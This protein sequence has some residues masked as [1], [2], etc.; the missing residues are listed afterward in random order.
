MPSTPSPSALTS[1]ISSNSTTQPSSPVFALS[2]QILHNL[3]HQHIWKSLQLHEPHSLSPQQHIPLISGYPPQTI[4]TH[5][6]EQ[7]YLL[8]HDIR[9]EAVPVEREWVIPCAQ[10]QSWSLRKFAGVF[11]SLPNRSDDIPEHKVNE[12]NPA[13]D[14]FSEFIRRKREEPWGGKRALLAMVNRGAGGDG[15]VVYYVMLEG[16][17]KPRQN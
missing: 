5:P 16:D 11:D 9:S 15:T 13:D 4:Y 17:V 6:D 2:L 7:A 12:G 3:E 10:G 1:L 14:K 8:E